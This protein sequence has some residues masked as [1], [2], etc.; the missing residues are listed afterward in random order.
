M[1]KALLVLNDHKKA[2][3]AANR[4]VEL[5]KANNRDYYVHILYVDPDCFELHPESGVCFWMP[6]RDL[7][8][9]LTSIRK[10]I[11]S[12]VTPIFVQLDIKPI[13]DV[14]RIN[15]DKIISKYIKQNGPFELVLLA[16]N[17]SKLC[18]QYNNGRRYLFRRQDPCAANVYCLI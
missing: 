7:I 13:V 5:I 2:L 4:F 17:H 3:D 8:A 14:A 15:S 18:C 11:M 16:S 12:D 9:E 10:K 6:G 1:K